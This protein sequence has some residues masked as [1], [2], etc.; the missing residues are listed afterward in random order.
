MTDMAA[1]T[2]GGP[3]DWLSICH[4]WQV[5]LAE[6]SFVGAEAGLNAGVPVTLAGREES[7]AYEGRSD[8]M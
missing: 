8:L 7:G 4:Q 2:M 1:V 5:R 6:E 3:G